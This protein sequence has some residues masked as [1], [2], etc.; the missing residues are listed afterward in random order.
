MIE[1][2]ELKTAMTLGLTINL[3][4]AFIISLTASKFP[5]RAAQSM[6]FWATGLFLLAASYFVF[7]GVFADETIFIIVGDAA[8]L[9]GIISMSH[10]V[11][12]YLKVNC[13]RIHLINALVSTLAITLNSMWFHHMVA[14]VLITTLSIIISTSAVLVPLL[15]IIKKHPTAAKVIILT[16]TLIIQLILIARGI[17]YMLSPRQ[18]WSFNHNSVVDF[19]TITLAVV[20]PVT[21]TFAFM[22][23]HQEKAYRELS[24]VA[25]IDGL[26]KIYNRHAIELKAKALFKQAI[27]N[28]T[29][30]AVL[31]IDLDKFKQI[32]DRYGHDA[33][34]QA[35]YTTA[36][37]IRKV[38]DKNHL[39]GRFGGE[40][41]LVLLPGYNLK[42]A[43]IKSE[44][45][46][47][48]F[49]QNAHSQDNHSYII[50]ASI[51]VSE[52]VDEEF[53]FATTLKRADQALYQAKNSGRNRVI[54]S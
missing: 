24:R 27:Q 33:G 16:F 30:I 14:P 11:G 22:L 18:A 1:T 12:I 7:S 49:R 44:Q 19:L 35:L 20:G 48:A 43:E 52:R 47:T 32:N 46:L 38:I 53:N 9:T 36:R 8:V 34:D 54:T 6:F 45:L 51:G 5:Q 15:K 39:V 40:E 28:Q 25:A 10:A 42:Q 41:F 13:L 26:T 50:T 23:L 21:T 29:N 3:I 4:M 17:D 31:L 2:V 37:I